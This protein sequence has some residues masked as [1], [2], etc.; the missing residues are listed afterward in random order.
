MTTPA[1]KESIHQDPC[2][3]LSFPMDL[4][5]SDS[6]DTHYANTLK[7]VGKKPF[8]KIRCLY[9]NNLC[10]ATY[11]GLNPLAGNRRWVVDWGQYFQLGI[12]ANQY[13]VGADYW[14]VGATCIWLRYWRIW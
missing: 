5:I 13:S 6:E 8:T 10:K 11:L 3:L 14:V 2:P 7:S 12:R 1:L 4:V 9:S